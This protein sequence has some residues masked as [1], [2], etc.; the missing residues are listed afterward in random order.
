MTRW[1]PSS[2]A[3]DA[4]H[5]AKPLKFLISRPGRFGIVWDICRRCKSVWAHKRWKCFCSICE[6]KRFTPSIDQFQINMTF[7]TLR[8]LI[9]D[10]LSSAWYATGVRLISSS[11]YAPVPTST[12]SF[13]FL[14]RATFG[15]QSPI[16]NSTSIQENNKANVDLLFQ[17][18]STEAAFRLRSL[19]L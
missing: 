13:G 3:K 19:F 14:I 8:S 1:Q 6:I 2:P 16:F 11:S 18:V 4:G 15:S 17:K 10:C 7:F 5:K 12:V 9:S